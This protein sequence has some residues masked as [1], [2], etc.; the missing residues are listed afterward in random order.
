MKE[1]LQNC[2]DTLNHAYP[3]INIDR[4]GGI[5]T[6]GLYYCSDCGQYANACK[7]EYPSLAADL[8]ETVARLGG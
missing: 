4:G 6:R 3:E 8:E 5:Y 2:L 7:E 1:L